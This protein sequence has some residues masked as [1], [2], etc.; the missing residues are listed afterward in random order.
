MVTPTSTDLALRPR[1][2]RHRADAASRLAV[3]IFAPARPHPPTGKPVGKAEVLKVTWWY[4]HQEAL[5]SRW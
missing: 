2:P 1:R 4:E 5:G 3:W